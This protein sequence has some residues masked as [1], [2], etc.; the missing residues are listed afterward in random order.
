MQRVDKDNRTLRQYLKLL[1]N[2]SV[3]TTLAALA[4]F[5]V[6][7]GTG[8]NY[9]PVEVY[10]SHN[11]DPRKPDRCISYDFHDDVS[12]ACGFTKEQFHTQMQVCQELRHA[13]SEEEEGIAPDRCSASQT[14]FGEYG[15]KE[16]NFRKVNHGNSNTGT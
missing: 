3:M 1:L 7:L 8:V 5:G 14:A 4:V 13:E 12:A 6:V 15:G 16:N 9:T 10:A 2:K 11:Q